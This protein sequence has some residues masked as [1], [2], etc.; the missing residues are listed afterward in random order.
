MNNPQD[1]EFTEVENNQKSGEKLIPKMDDA[2]LKGVMVELECSIGSTQVALSDF[3]SLERGEVLK[4]QQAINDE[5]TLS[6]N[7]VTVAAGKLV[8][9][10][11]HF[12]VEITQVPDL[13]ND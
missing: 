8:A 4:L 3:A 2:L 9:I 5:I 11:G 7:G 6:I 13:T 1:V 12:G 10:D